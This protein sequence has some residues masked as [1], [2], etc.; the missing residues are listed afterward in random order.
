[1]ELKKQNF[2]SWTLMFMSNCLIFALLT[3]YCLIALADSAIVIFFVNFLFF[4][5]KGL[6]LVSGTC[7]H[8]CSHLI[9]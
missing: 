3:A 7:R 4:I 6:S 5:L 8:H 9:H 2:W 1:M